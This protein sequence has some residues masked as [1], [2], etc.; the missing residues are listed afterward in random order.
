MN[1]P[2]V[3]LLFAGGLGNKAAP[4]GVGFNVGSNYDRLSPGILCRIAHYSTEIAGPG[5]ATGPIR[6]DRERSEQFR[7]AI[8]SDLND[9]AFWRRALPLALSGP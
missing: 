8:L 3:P 2:C 4:A 5:V 9:H 6:F 7:S 1:L